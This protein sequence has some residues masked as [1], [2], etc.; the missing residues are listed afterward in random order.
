MERVDT[1]QSRLCLNAIIRGN[2]NKE[3]AAILNISPNTVALHRANLINALGVHRTADLVI[4]AT[5]K[6]LVTP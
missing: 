2:S 1:S 3:I 5:R 6:G 4:Y